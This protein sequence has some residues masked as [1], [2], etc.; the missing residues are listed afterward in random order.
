MFW[1]AGDSE[2][3]HGAP[4]CDAVCVLPAIVTVVLRALAPFGEA[5]SATVPP[6]VPDAPPVIVSQLGS[7]LTA[8]HEHQLPVVTVTPVDPPPYASDDD[9]GEI[10]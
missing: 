3:T 6:P 8:V 10:E 2:K 7:L 4:A 9:D 1:L 5:A